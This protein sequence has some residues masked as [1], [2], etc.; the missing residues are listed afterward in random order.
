M[1]AIHTPEFA[2]I[3]LKEYCR[4]LKEYLLDMLTDFEPMFCMNH[5]REKSEIIRF[6]WSFVDIFDLRIQRVSV[7][8]IIVKVCFKF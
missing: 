8:R 5:M 1:L 7:I 6:H 3:D 4:I 2:G